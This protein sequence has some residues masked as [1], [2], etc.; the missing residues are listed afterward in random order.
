MECPSVTILNQAR[1]MSAVKGEVVTTRKT[2]SVGRDTLLV[3][4]LSV[5]SRKEKVC[6]ANLQGD[7]ARMWKIRWAA[8]GDKRF[9][10]KRVGTDML[11]V[12]L[13]S[14]T[15]TVPHRR[16]S[17]LGDLEGKCSSNS[18]SSDNILT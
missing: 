3:C 17:D 6:S 2:K 7:G 15:S 13:D 1:Q 4:S 11:G 14:I 8:F 10:I 18:R 9:R 16:S 12:W 5:F